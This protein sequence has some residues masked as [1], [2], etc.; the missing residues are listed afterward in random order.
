[1]R[2]GVC[3]FLVSA[4]ACTG[5]LAHIPLDSPR[6]PTGLAVT[7]DGETLL[8]VSSNFDLAFEQG[9]LLAADLSRVRD[10]ID[11]GDDA[12]DKIIKDAYR[13]A[14]FV[15][16]FGDR[17]ALTSDGKRVLVPTRGSNLISS[18]DIDGRELR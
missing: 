5:E 3:L 17:P 14:A 11:G 7:P 9:A 13:S 2:L 16:S 4:S 12:G 10:A 8:V 15:P 18:L 1:M 6:F